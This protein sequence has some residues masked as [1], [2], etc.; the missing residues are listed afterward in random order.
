M[1][2]ENQKDKNENDEKDVKETNENENVFVIT[3]F[4]GKEGGNVYG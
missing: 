3:G 2:N 4:L 1:K